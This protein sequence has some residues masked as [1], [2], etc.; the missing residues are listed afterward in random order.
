MKIVIFG[1]TGSIGSFL[2]KKYCDNKN[3]LL[4]FVKNQKSKKK[5]IKLLNLRKN[6]NVIIDCI[7]IEKKD[8]IKKKLIKYNF[9]LKNL[10]LV[11]NATGSLG[12]IKSVT[13]MN[14]KNFEKTLK[15]NFFSNLFILQK[16]LKLKKKK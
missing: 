15:I 3:K 8:S 1:A 14:I 12:E 6:N 5:L 16:I 10:D 11:I 7:N 13:N 4:L 9:F 2:T